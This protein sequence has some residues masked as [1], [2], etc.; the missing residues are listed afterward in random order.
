MGQAH[1]MGV[2]L[3]H[4]RLG[5]VEPD[6]GGGCGVG[7]VGEGRHGS[8][9]LSREQETGADEH[10]VKRVNRRR[11]TAPARTR[12]HLRGGPARPRSPRHL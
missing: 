2:T 11:V 6:P 12:S 9:S 4:H 5:P 10:S 7:T 8:E 1:Q 3:D